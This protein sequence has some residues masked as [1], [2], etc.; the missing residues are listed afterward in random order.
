MKKIIGLAALACSLALGGCASIISDSDYPVTFNASPEGVSYTVVNTKKDLVMAA[1]TTPD[2]VVLSADNGFFSRASYVVTFEKENY[3]SVSMPLKAGMD[4]WYI[5]NV[6]LGG[7]IGILI[8]DPAT[9]AMWSL[10]DRVDVG[11]TPVP[12]TPPVNQPVAPPV[13]GTEP[14][15]AVSNDL[16][17]LDYDQLPQAYRADLIRIN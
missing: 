2:T 15:P 3:E 11:L 4:G 12:V 17:V 1:G 5:G 14:E 6:L 9:G 16:S 13:P 10:D 7:L 8:V